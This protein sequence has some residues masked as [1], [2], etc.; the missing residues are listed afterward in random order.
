M[1]A[2]KVQRIEWTV[3]GLGAE[4]AHDL[5]DAIKKYRVV[6]AKGSGVAWSLDQTFNAKHGIETVGVEE[7]SREN[8]K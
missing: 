8:L 7:W 4:L 3:P 1:P 6:F 5:D 2:E